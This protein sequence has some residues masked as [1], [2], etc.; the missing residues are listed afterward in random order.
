MSD[1]KIPYIFYLYLHSKLWEMT[2]GEV[3]SEKDLKIMLFQW[4]IPKNIRPLI[5]KEMELLGLIKEEGRFSIRLNR[6]IFNEEK[7]NEYYKLLNIF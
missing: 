6:P 3:V 5:V 4:K 1:I 2:K 7:I